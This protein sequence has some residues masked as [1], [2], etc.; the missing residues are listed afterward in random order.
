MEQHEL[1][2]SSLQTI[3]NLFYGYHFWQTQFFLTNEFLLFFFYSKRQH[4]L[5]K[6]HINKPQLKT[7]FENMPKLKDG[8]LIVFSF[9]F[10]VKTANQTTKSL[11]PTSLP[12]FKLL[13]DRKQMPWSLLLPVQDAYFVLQWTL[14]YHSVL[15]WV[16]KESTLNVLSGSQKQA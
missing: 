4:Q 10:P 14:V 8:T 1:L 16:I 11:R 6:K 7:E 2:N 5:Q 3:K 15:I 13:M 9:I 12:S